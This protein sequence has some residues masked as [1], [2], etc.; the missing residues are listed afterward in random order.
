ML[1]VIRLRRKAVQGWFHPAN[2]KSD[3]GRCQRRKGN[4][5]GAAYH[6]FGNGIDERN[7]IDANLVT[8]C[9]GY[10]Q[11]ARTRST[12]ARDNGRSFTNGGAAVTAT[13]LCKYQSDAGDQFHRPESI[14][15]KF[16]A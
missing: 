4:I 9:A 6:A 3:A 14:P 16:P 10:R 1:S 13:V 5:C 11:C 7:I 15:D 8:Q 12:I 2:T